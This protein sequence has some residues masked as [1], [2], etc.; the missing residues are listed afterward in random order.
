MGWE[1]QGRTRSQGQEKKNKKNSFLS[2]GTTTRTGFSSVVVPL[3][4]SPDSEGGVGAGS[5]EFAAELNILYGNDKKTKKKIN[6]L[7]KGERTIEIVQEVSQSLQHTLFS[8]PQTFQSQ[9][10]IKLQ[11]DGSFLSEAT[12]P[13]TN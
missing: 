10:S 3:L 12:R 4:Q 2:A 11:R 7:S 1:L 9:L 8:R 6:I 5:L 13:L